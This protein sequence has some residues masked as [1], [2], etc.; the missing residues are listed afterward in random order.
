MCGYVPIIHVTHAPTFEMHC[1]QMVLLNLDTRFFQSVTLRHTDCIENAV[2]NA[3]ALVGCG[4]EDNAMHAWR[5]GWSGL[6]P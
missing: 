5:I 1:Q 2:L 3:A 6:V 4:A